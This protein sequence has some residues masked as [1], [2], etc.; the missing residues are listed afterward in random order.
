M[1]LARCTPTTLTPR[2]ISTYTITGFAGY[3]AANVVAAILSSRWELSLG[4]RLVGFFAPPLAFI[5]VVMIATAIVG[6]ERIVF[7]QTACAGFA[8]VVI[9]GLIIG[10]RVDRLIDLA[11]IGIGV[12]LVFG[13]IGCHA[14][15]CCHGTL[16]RGVSYGPAHVAVGFWARWS[17][18][19]L[20]PVQA[21][22]AL[23]SALLVATALVCSSNPG[24]AGLVYIVG[25]AAL[26]FGLELLRGDVFRP[27]A[28]GL[29]EAQWIS[30][31]AVLGC[32]AWR[33]GP[34]TLVV[35]GALV[36]SAAALVATRHRRALFTPPH[37]RALERALVA[38]VDGKRHVT[39]LGVGVS[40]NVL[41]DGRIDWILSAPDLTET[42][43]RRLAH[44]M[45]PHWELVP[46]RTPG[47]VHVLTSA[48]G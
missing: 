15:A 31:A 14:V 32:A 34:A 11:T 44:L 7:Y 46:A 8:A 42:A 38:A 37:L 6:K 21:I 35:A 29:S 24:T 47:M 36:V 4:E 3:G 40:R 33:P 17:G 5:F 41:P 28:L 16:G 18:R 12:F 45:W 23:A 10:G 9:A 1:E 30:V 22:E 43:A 20:W 19:A 13:R 2:R 26:R 48:S 27:Y 25:Y 39:S